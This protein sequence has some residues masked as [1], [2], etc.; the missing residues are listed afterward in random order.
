MDKIKACQFANL[1]YYSRYKPPVRTITFAAP[2]TTL[3]NF[4]ALVKC[5]STFHIGT[6]TGYD[7]H[8]QDLAGNE[9]YFDLDFYDSVTGNGAWWVQIPSLTSS[10]PTSIKML[11]GD[12]SVAAD[13]S[14][15]TTVWSGYDYIYHF[16]GSDPLKDRMGSA[17]LTLASGIT[18]TV[19][20]SNSQTGQG[21]QLVS[22]GTQ[23]ITYG[24]YANVSSFTY[25]IVAHASECYAHGLKTDYYS[26]GFSGYYSFEI[27]G[28]GKT[29]T[30]SVTFPSFE[31]LSFSG[32]SAGAFLIFNGTGYDCSTSERQDW[33]RD[34]SH[35][36]QIR[37]SCVY[38]LDEFRISKTVQKS[39]AW[40]SYEQAQITDHATYTTYGPEA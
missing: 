29:F 25:L 8:F 26:Y 40:L 32:G 37:P 14:S 12:S 30:P 4:P 27:Y 15:P 35:A 21:L 18:G 11:Y 6:S 31:A 7:V 33:L 28:A 16:S 39:S 23:N 9:L 19:V 5:N 13:G 20:T 3:T 2:S 36:I 17:D 38:T 34:E 10:G 24:S 22:T 1:A